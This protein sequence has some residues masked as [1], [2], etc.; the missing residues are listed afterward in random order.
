MHVFLLRATDDVQTIIGAFSTR[1]AA[2]H[3]ATEHGGDTTVT[4]LEI[5]TKDGRLQLTQCP[6]P[7]TSYGVDSE[8]E[9]WNDKGVREAGHLGS[10]YVTH[11][12][13]DDAGECHAMAHHRIV[14]WTLDPTYDINDP[15]LEVD[16]RDGCTTNNHPSNLEALTKEEHIKKTQRDNPG[17]FSVKGAL[18]RRVAVLHTCPDTG[19]VRPYESIALAAAAN[20]IPY[21]DMRKMLALKADGWEH[22]Q[23]DIAGES[24]YTPANESVDY[25][26]SRGDK[27]AL[28]ISVSDKGRVRYGARATFGSPTGNGGFMLGKL[29]VSWLVNVC[30]NGPPPPGPKVCVIHL[31]GK[32]GNNHPN[33]LAWS[34]NNC[35]R[36]PPR[37]YALPVDTT[38]YVRAIAVEVVEDL[39]TKDELASMRD[40]EVV[41]VHADRLKV[42][43]EGFVATGESASILRGMSLEPNAKFSVDRTRKMLIKGG[44][45]ID[46]KRGAENSKRRGYK[47]L[48]L[49]WEGF[50]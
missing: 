44:V 5:G 48:N 18:T 47:L 21:D 49:R 12:L 4:E 16:H 37:L 29:P 31:D 28:N 2:E 3:R 17:R 24:W 38:D 40:G 43:W 36:V 41:V 8:G 7:Y 50:S 32:R 13:T 26:K 20:K 23:K 22:A 42:A 39:L 30:F 34:S 46:L 10:K 35:R 45:R 6:V 25:W 1:G 15:D 9:L 33:N 19:K 11:R 14:L 27:Q